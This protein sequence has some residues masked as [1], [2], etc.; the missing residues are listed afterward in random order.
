MELF[1]RK[2]F[3]ATTV[4]EIAAAAGVS[5][6][7]FFR[8]FPSKEA[9]ALDDPYDPLIADLI[10]AQDASLPALERVRG[11]LLAAWQ[12]VPEPTDRQTVDRIRLVAGHPGL[13]AAMW[14][15]NHRTEDL[16]ARALIG[17]GV[18]RVEARVAAGACLGGL[19]AALLDWAR[20]SENGGVGEQ[21]RTA[22][23]LMGA[24]AE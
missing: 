3:D 2:G 13:R 24:S 4:A 5:P 8:H 19:T 12:S 7:T 22:L 21:I 15:N 16:I 11:G 9:A 1:L 20:S 6:M 17:A 10:L 23:A 14:E 18:D